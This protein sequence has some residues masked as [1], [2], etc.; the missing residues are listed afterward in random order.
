[1]Q[2][3]SR[4]KLGVLQLAGGLAAQP[5]AVATV[6]A[7]VAH[8]RVGVHSPALGVES[9]GQCASDMSAEAVDTDHM[10]NIAQTFCKRK[11]NLWQTQHALVPRLEVGGLRAV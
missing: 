5:V 2:K 8:E 11:W 9:V 4:P 10:E 6:D 3:R 1:V 7:P